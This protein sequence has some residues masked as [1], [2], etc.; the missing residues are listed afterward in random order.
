[1][2]SFASSAFLWLFESS[3]IHSG[4]LHTENHRCLEGSPD[5]TYVSTHYRN[6]QVV[7]EVTVKHPSLVM[8]EYLRAE[9]VTRELQALS[10]LHEFCGSPGWQERGDTNKCCVQNSPG[11]RGIEGICST[12]VLS[13]GCPEQVMLALH[14]LQEIWG[15]QVCGECPAVIRQDEKTQASLNNAKQ[16]PALWGC[17]RTGD[18]KDHA[19][20][21][22]SWQVVANEAVK[23]Q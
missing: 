18:W 1:M 7:L 19:V 22:F 17:A 10:K 15:C 20:A 3:F 21:F 8:L 2:W 14:L 12:W 13:T 11:S 9:H 6:R 5:E 4:L 16:V 23:M